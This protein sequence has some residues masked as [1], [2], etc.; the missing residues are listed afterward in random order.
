MAGILK[1]PRHKAGS[2]PFCLPT[3]TGWQTGSF[4]SGSL[5]PP[6]LFEEG[7]N[8][9]DLVSLPSG[10]RIGLPARQFLTLPVWLETTDASVIVPMAQAQLES[11]GWLRDTEA[12]PAW[13]TLLVCQENGR[14]LVSVF[15][16]NP[17]LPPHLLVSQAGSY[18]IAARFR[19]LPDNAYV[20]WREH[21]GIVVACS[22]NHV[23]AYVE[24]FPEASRTAEIEHELDALR[25]RLTWENVM[26]LDAPTLVWGTPE[27]IVA[28]PFPLKPLPRCISP[29]PPLALIP[30]FIREQRKQHESSTHRKGL[31]LGVALVYALTLLVGLTAFAHLKWREHRLT[32][33][34][35]ETA[36]AVEDLSRAATRWQAVG[37]AIDTS[38]YPMEC[39]LACVQQLPTEVR[40]TQFEHGPAKVLLMGEGKDAASIFRFLNSVKSDPFLRKWEWQM[41]QPQVLP[42]NR[43]QFQLE[44]TR[45]TTSI[46]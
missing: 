21:G 27:E 14:S 9:A 38:Y 33:S 42:N 19:P 7:M 10:V 23:L 29:V 39:L 5:A 24:Y 1:W 28:H 12:E 40:L 36:A 16:V 43:A 46:N 22:R 34:L 17:S 2:E 6:S 44:G 26:P 32:A 30:P 18:D 35:K 31:Y 3:A 11:R 4:A 37:P 13:G 25:R 45:V 41:P 8:D 20:L 15:M